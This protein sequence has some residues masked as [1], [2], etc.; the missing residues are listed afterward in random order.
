MAA[1]VKKGA[2]YADRKGRKF[3]IKAYTDKT[4]KKIRIADKAGNER[5]MPVTRFKD[6]HKLVSAAPKAK[7]A[8]AKPAKAKARKKVKAA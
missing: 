7:K 4:M 8:A 2:I 5:T 6:E 3:T 1:S